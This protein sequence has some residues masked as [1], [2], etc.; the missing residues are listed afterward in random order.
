MNAQQTM[1]AAIKTRPVQIQ[2]VRLLVPVT[3]DLQEMGHL[4]LRGNLMNVQLEQITAMSSRL[5][6]ILP[7]PMSALASLA[8]MEMALTVRILM[9]AQRTMEV[10][11]LTRLAAT[12][13]AHIRVHVTRVL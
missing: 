13:S 12:V 2:M 1:G 6:P 11:I 7:H 9:N 4:V 5:V 3:L 10:A 8:L